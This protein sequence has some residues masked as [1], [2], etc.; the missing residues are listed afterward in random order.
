[1]PRSTNDKMFYEA[2]RASEN[3]LQ[4]EAYITSL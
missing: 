4:I 2:L 3:L 1:M